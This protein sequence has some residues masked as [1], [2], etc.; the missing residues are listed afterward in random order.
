M[1]IFSQTNIRLGMPSI[2]PYESQICPVRTGKGIIRNLNTPHCPVPSAIGMPTGDCRQSGI[3]GDD[4]GKWRD[5]R[6]NLG[7]HEKNTPPPDRQRRDGQYF[8]FFAFPFQIRQKFP[9]ILGNGNK[10]RFRFSRLLSCLVR[11]FSQDLFVLP[12]SSVKRHAFLQPSDNPETVPI[13]Y[14]IRPASFRY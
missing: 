2:L 6:G 10:A 12:S 4:Q 7:M 11:R 14:G 3:V 1:S 5:V 8:K 9:G 13:F